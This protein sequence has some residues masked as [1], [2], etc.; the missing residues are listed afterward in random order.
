[1]FGPNSLAA[2]LLQCSPK[3][4]LELAKTLVRPTRLFL[5]DL[6]KKSLLSGKNFGSIDRV[7]VLCKEDEIISEDFQRWF[8]ENNPTKD[9]KVIE[10]A[11]HMAMLSKPKELCQC[12]VE[13]AEE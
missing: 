13:I 9:V 1:M 8:I 3:E 7:F 2:K 6:A 11:D 4:D 12:F 5:K 10:G